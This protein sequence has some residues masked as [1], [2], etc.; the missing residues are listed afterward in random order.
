MTH[1]RARF[2]FIISVY[3]PQTIPFAGQD[4]SEA[5]L[6]DEAGQEKL[7][8]FFSDLI[9]GLDGLIS[10]KELIA[11]SGH[12]EWQR[13]ISLFYD[14]LI[15]LLAS[16]DLK[17]SAEPGMAF[18]PALHEAVDVTSDP[19]LPSGAIADVIQAG[20]LYRGKVLRY[21]KVVVAKSG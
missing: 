4:N 12:E 1:P 2:P 6:P 17:M 21:A 3:G 7:S 15:K 13:G 20:W 18:D 10:V 8:A 19:G 9:S 11:E 16:N 14:K 5:L